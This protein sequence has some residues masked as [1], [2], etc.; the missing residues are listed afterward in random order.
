MVSTIYLRMKEP[1]AEGSIRELYEEYYSSEPF[2]RVLPAGTFPD[3]V[4]VRG[5]NQ[6]HVSV[7][8]DE[9]TGWLIAISAID[10]LTKGASGLAVQNMNVMMGLQE[11][12]G[13]EGLPVFP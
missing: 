8:V 9:R 6:C 12:T 5:S 7:T 13:L 10:N 4:K 3:T 1:V 2:M 11:T